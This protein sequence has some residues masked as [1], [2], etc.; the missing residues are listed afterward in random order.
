[1]ATIPRPVRL[2]AWCVAALLLL[3]WAGCSGGDN[4]AVSVTLS[5]APEDA[6]LI[7]TSKNA[8][9]VETSNFEA[10]GVNGNKDIYPTE[11]TTYTITVSNG[12]SSATD[13]VTVTLQD[14]P[15]A[16][17]PG[18]LPSEPFFV[19]T[20]NYYYLYTTQTA[21]FPAVYQLSTGLYPVPFS[22]Q[23]IAIPPDGFDIAQESERAVTMLAQADPRISIISGV[24]PENAR[25]QVSLVESISYGE[26]NNIIGLTKAVLNGGTPYYDVSVVTID[27]LDGSPMPFYEIQR[28]LTHEFGH[29]FG[30]GHTPDARD[31]MYF[32]SNFQQGVTPEK[33]LTLGDAIAQWTTLNARSV[34]WYPDRP[35]ITPAGAGTLIL[36]TRNR[37]KRV[38]DEGGVVICVSPR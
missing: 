13:T 2:A 36:D 9:R 14:V 30:L 3:V 24:A 20:N 7:W 37:R 5:A 16:P 27:P 12:S 32:Q 11:T 35:V 26:Q 1:M 17:Q 25:V 22:Y 34:I 18:A 19:H 23:S 4:N 8:T 28:T 6:R 31:L 38:T 33:F 10:T 15:P 29:V 21:P